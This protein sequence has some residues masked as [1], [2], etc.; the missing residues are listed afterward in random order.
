MWLTMR[1]LQSQQALVSRS[2]LQ[3]IAHQLNAS[4]GDVSIKLRHRSATSS[5]RRRTSASRSFR[6]RLPLNFISMGSVGM[7]SRALSTS[8]AAR[9]SSSRVEAS[10]TS[11]CSCSRIRRRCSCS[12]P[13]L[14]AACKVIS[15]GFE[16][17]TRSTSASA[18]MAAVK[19]RAPISRRAF[20]SNCRALAWRAASSI[21]R[22]RAT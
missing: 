17:S 3:L 20:S 18:S 12:R 11:F 21:R 1:G 7:R 15:S 16:G 2:L 5:T 6:A 8:C 13:D 19:W 10:E 22:A 14:A 4:S 9:V